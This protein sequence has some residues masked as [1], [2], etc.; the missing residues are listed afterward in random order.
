MVNDSWSDKDLENLFAGRGSTEG[1]LARLAPLVEALRLEVEIPARA[2]AKTVAPMLAR[3]AKKAVVDVPAKAPRRSSPWKRR[4][5]TIG[6]VTAL[7]TVGV[8]GAAIASNGAAPGDVLYSIDQAF[9]AIGIG[10]GGTQERLD[11]AVRLTERGQPDRA[12]EHAANALRKGGD[13]DSAQALVQAAVAV[14]NGGA[15]QSAEVRSQVSEMLQWM[16]STDSHGRDFGQGVSER[17]RGIEETV[18]HGK[19]AEAPGHDKDDDDQSGDG[20]DGSSGQSDR[21]S[22]NSGKGRKD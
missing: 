3:E 18:S 20:G 8:G 16:E 21:P 2:D 6:G 15:E 12:L 1:D 19:S 13:Q 7:V 9:E 11:E 22:G 5:V 10:D 17:A 4:L 14:Q